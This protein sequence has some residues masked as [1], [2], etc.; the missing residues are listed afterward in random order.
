[1]FLLVPAYPG[2]P[3]SKAVKRSLLWCLGTYGSS[4][5]SLFNFARWLFFLDMLL[6]LIWLL[7]ILLPQS[8]HFDYTSVTDTFHISDLINGMVLTYSHLSPT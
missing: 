2:C 5:G 7:L 1:M 3:G 6:F 4:V 8:I